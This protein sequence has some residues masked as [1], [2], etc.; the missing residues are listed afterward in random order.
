MVAGGLAMIAA[1]AGFWGESPTGERLCLIGF[2][3][4]AVFLIFRSL[5]LQL[6]EF[7]SRI[8][9]RSRL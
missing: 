4:A 1:G 3:L 9:T 2:F 6:V 5:P 8:I 7:W